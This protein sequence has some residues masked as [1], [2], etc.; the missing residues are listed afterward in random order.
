MKTAWHRILAPVTPGV[1]ILWI[2]IAAL[3]LA[4]VAG[5]FSHAYNLYPWLALSGPGF[6]SGRVWTVVTYAFLPATLLDLLFN[7]LALV[8]LGSQL[9][10][11]W[12]R[13]QLWTYCLVAAVGA[14]LVKVL[15]QPATPRL[16]VGTAPL[17]FAFIAAWAW[18]FGHEKVMFFW[19]M[20]VRQSAALL[21]LIG[22]VMLFFSVGMMDAVL[23]LCG[24][25]AGWCYLL[26][27]EKIRRRQPS[28][29]V[30][31]ER[32]GRLEL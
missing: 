23:T 10:R 22:A 2:V 9:E 21:A 32:I 28:R 12:P 6:L 29:R 24:G 14:G 20:T 19:E 8:F 27:A 11:V 18:V 7:G 4:R 26:V 17:F 31:S 1:R 25:V 16:F 30:D 3:F 13:A 5:T 15:L